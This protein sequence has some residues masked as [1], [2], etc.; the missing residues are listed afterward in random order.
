MKEHI[1]IGIDNGV[2]GSI[3]VTG[4]FNHFQKTPVKKELSYTKKKQ[5]ISRLDAI[6]FTEL[7]T[8]YLPYY[9]I[10]VA[11][12]RPLVNPGMFKTTMSAMRCLEST[13]CVLELMRLPYIY[14][15]S[16]EWQ[17]EMLPSGLKGSPMLKKAS[18]DIGCRLFPQF[19]EVIVKQKDADGILMSEWYRRN[20]K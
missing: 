19:K 2:S 5:F 20:Y 6:E 15:D 7:L 18:L 4:V 12:E 17:K 9:E 1:F 8:A 14:V 11:L 13:I 16:K 10:H 3:G